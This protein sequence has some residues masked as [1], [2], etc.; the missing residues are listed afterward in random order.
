MTDLIAGFT[1]S[2]SYRS[3]AEA[4]LL[5]RPDTGLR[6][7]SLQ[8]V[9]EA[10]FSFDALLLDDHSAPLV[11]L[12]FGEGDKSADDI[13]AA[14]S[15]KLEGFLQPFGKA[16]GDLVALQAKALHSLSDL[17][18]GTAADAAALSIDIR[19]AR[20]EQTYGVSGSGQTGIFSGFALEISV[21]TALV[22]FD[23][24]RSMVISMAGERVEFSSLQ[25][26][27][28]H[29]LGVFRRPAPGLGVMPECASEQAEEARKIIAFL[30]ETRRQIKAFQ[31]PEERAYRGVLYQAVQSFSGVSVRV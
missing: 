23:P 30:K 28:G 22:D 31:E 27:E 10:S 9:Q 17:I 24:G 6:S 3:F 7:F 19:F 29:R 16:G 2:R 18:E 4:S 1:A 15:E 11:S 20:T 26:I 12:P 25:M 14:L 8:R 21:S 13:L 5:T